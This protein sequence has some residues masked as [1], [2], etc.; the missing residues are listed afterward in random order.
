MRYSA[1]GRLRR[2]RVS[3]ER[4]PCKRIAK[5]QATV[6]SRAAAPGTRPRT[7]AA[8]STGMRVALHLRPIVARILRCPGLHARRDLRSS[9]HASPNMRGGAG[10]HARLN[11]SGNS[12][13]HRRC[14]RTFVP[15][16]TLHTPGPLLRLKQLPF[17]GKQITSLGDHT[18][19]RIEHAKVDPQV[20]G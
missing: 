18:I 14:G 20:I 17:D 2:R 10:L 12:G 11:L 19:I 6:L 15:V 8:I 9:V 4:Q 16:S 1:A 13:T 7:A 3:A 5:T